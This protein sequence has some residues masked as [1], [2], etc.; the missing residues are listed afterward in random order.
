M[1]Q[2]KRNLFNTSYFGK[3][4][5]FIGTYHSRV[6]HIEE[7]FSG[8]VDVAI[9]VA[10]P[11]LTYY[12]KDGDIYTINSSWRLNSQ[13]QLESVGVEALPVFLCADKID[14]HFAESSV[15]LLELSIKDDFDNVIYTDT[16]DTAKNKVFNIRQKYG[17]KW[18]YLK[19]T[20]NNKTILTHITARVSNITADILSS[21]LYQSQDPNDLDQS[22]SI[23][24]PDSLEPDANGWLYGQTSEPLG[25]TAA[26][27]IKLTMMSSDTK[28][29][30]SPVVDVIKLSSGDINSYTDKGTWQVAINM[31]NVAA[32]IDKTFGRTK[33]LEYE[34][35]SKESIEEDV[36]WMER[37][38]PIRSASKK[39]PNKNDS[40][41]PTDLE[42]KGSFYWSPETATYRQ[43]KNQVARRI[44]LGHKNNNGFSEDKEY[45]QVLFGPYS[46]E[47][48]PYINTTLL[49]WNQLESAFSFPTDTTGS[50]VKIQVWDNPDMI[51]YLPVFERTLTQDTMTPI[52]PIELTELHEEIYIGFVFYST[53][54]TQTPVVDT[55][56]LFYHLHYDKLINYTDEV[57][58]LD[59]MYGERNLALAGDGTKLLRRVNTRD[60]ALP[61]K[62][63]NKN[64]DILIKPKYP[65]QQ[66]IYYGDNDGIP[67]DNQTSIGQ[68]DS[69]NI[70]SRV[71]PEM[72]RA[73]TL[74]VPPNKL[75]WHFQYDGGT[76]SYPHTVEKEVSTDFTPSL[77]QNKKYK[78]AVINGWPQESISLPFNMTW[79]EVA[80]LGGSTIEVLQELNPNIILYNNKIQAGTVIN[81]ENKTANQVVTILYKSN[82]LLYTKKSI[83]NGDVTNDYIVA[84]VTGDI[85]EELPWRSE[86]RLF[87]GILN[88]NNEQLSYVRTQ[89]LG[90]NNDAS[91][92]LIRNTS[93]APKSY[94]QISEEQ[95]VSVA[96]LLLANNLL[97]YYDEADE[98]YIQPGETVVIPPY[99]SLPEV[100]NNIFYEGDNP[101]KVEIVPGSL[102]KTFD[103][104]VLSDKYIKSGSDDEEAIQYTKVESEEKEHVLTRGN[105]RHGRDTLPYSNIHRIVS[106]RNNV[107]GVTYT[108]YNSQTDKGDYYLDNGMI[109]WAPDA[110]DSKEPEAGQKY[111]VRFT[112]FIIDSLKLIYTTDYFEKISYNKLWRSKEIKEIKAIVTPD[113]DIYVDLPEFTEFSDYQN[114]IEQA[115]YVV[116]DNDLW[117]KSSL[118]ETEEGP[119]VKL[120]FEGKDPKRNWFPTINKGFYYLNDQEYYMYSEPIQKTFRDEALP[121]IEEAYYHDKGLA[122]LPSQEYSRSLINNDV[123]WTGILDNT[124][125]YEEATLTSSPDASNSVG[126]HILILT[127]L[128]PDLE[129]VSLTQRVGEIPAGAEISLRIK[130]PNQSTL[131]IKI[132]QEVYSIPNLS[133]DWNTYQFVTKAAGLDIILFTNNHIDFSFIDI[134]T[135]S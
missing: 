66:Y 121:V 33:R 35:T 54:N 6:S 64:Y 26:V 34:Y 120:S 2:F 71:I 134:T 49:N 29:S 60:F 14:L 72:P 18:L 20:L 31:N 83:W 103:G 30:G 23:K 73:S 109:S 86:E 50:Y 101:Y 1:A 102:T 126:G 52:I 106:I 62:S 63:I 44:S 41:I 17:N 40:T 5:A 124:W 39:L 56:T 7:S 119:K 114:Y 129:N 130:S 117:V 82:N 77:I 122:G 70:Y 104:I 100:P 24:F 128:Y 90:L 22:M 3:S 19:P 112:N 51:N 15:G 11:S 115:D 99:P 93:M 116:E 87:A 36:N 125:E 110:V 13:D 59:N 135:K 88:P 32:D 107:T 38:L 68:V 92:R 80:D 12:P 95:K 131:H 10:L 53:Q 65:N 79:S 98:L 47:V 96:D 37:Y 78:F 21:S 76:V 8:H 97:E 27:G 9:K 74:T 85:E 113:K 84:K 89:Q 108:P 118:E 111:T 16:I 75:Y 57:S 25:N 123:F 45:A 132:G 91:T 61:E 69:F 105:F 48:M 4:Y 42:V 55:T 94:K 58:G 67:F 43:Y 81:L 46:K 28:Q 127:S 133:N